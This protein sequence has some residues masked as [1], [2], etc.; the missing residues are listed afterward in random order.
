MDS[1][2]S[3]IKSK[4]ANNEGGV[5][6][7]VGSSQSASKNNIKGKKDKGKNEKTPK[8]AQKT[9]TVPTGQGS[10]PS[11]KKGAKITYPKLEQDLLQD[12]TKEIL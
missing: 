5:G 7:F 9:S 1:R 12:D 2:R 11:V 8:G 10:R 4:K 3:D 6:C